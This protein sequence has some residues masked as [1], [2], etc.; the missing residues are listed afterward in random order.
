MRINTNDLK[1]SVPKITL[2]LVAAISATAASGYY[3]VFETSVFKW[4]QDGLEKGKE[5]TKT[6]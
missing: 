5:E 2:N 1:V 3:R 6:Y 4:V